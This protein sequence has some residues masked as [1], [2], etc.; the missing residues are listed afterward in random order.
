MD[1]IQKI[2]IGLIFVLYIICIICICYLFS[3]YNYLDTISSSKL[4]Y[5]VYPL[6]DKN[7]SMTLGLI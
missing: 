1:N 7:N 6:F 5:V 4:D 3:K 2:I